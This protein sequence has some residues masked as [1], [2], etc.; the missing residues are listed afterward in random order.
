MRAVA[1]A[2]LE[3]SGS[4]RQDRHSILMTYVLH[5]REDDMPHYHERV[6]PQQDMGRGV[7]LLSAGRAPVRGTANFAALGAP[8]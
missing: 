3:V 4:L 8:Y 1:S 7:R 2:T 5:G 6:T